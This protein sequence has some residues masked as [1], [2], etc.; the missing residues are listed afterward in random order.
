MLT[1][2]VSCIAC[3]GYSAH[4][5]AQFRDAAAILDRVNQCHHHRRHH[6]LLLCLHNQ[7]DLCVHVVHHT[8]ILLAFGRNFLEQGWRT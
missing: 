1:Q 2:R 6:R 3:L 7:Q 5:V 4:S 8:I